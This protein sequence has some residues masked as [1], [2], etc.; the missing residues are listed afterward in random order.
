[1]ILA[2]KGYDCD[3]LIDQIRSQKAEAIIRSRISRKIERPLDILK[4]KKRCIIE[5]FFWKNEIF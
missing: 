2:D 3:K 1:M 4:Y 5:I